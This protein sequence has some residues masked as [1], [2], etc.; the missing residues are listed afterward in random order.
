MKGIDTTLDSITATPEQGGGGGTSDYNQLSHKPTIDGKVIEGDGTSR[1]YGLVSFQPQET[2]F[3]ERQIARG[4]IDAH[5]LQVDGKKMLM[6]LHAKGF[7]SHEEPDKRS[8]AIRL[9]EESALG[10]Y[11]S[12]LGIEKKI[13]VPTLDYA[14]IDKVTI[15]LTEAVI[16]PSATSSKIPPF[17]AVF[18]LDSKRVSEGWMIVGCSLFEAKDG[19][20]N[21]VYPFVVQS[22]TMEGGSKVKVS[23]YSPY[24]E[25]G[26]EAEM[27]SVQATIARIPA[28]T[29]G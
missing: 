2:R 1:E 17:A 26:I 13:V 12:G 4:N 22:F 7:D 27:L 14:F 16:I 23:F 28:Q 15:K 24:P 20:G 18:E 6:Y 10:I 29:G 25:E 3:I 8:F 21:R 5:Y 19:K 9:V 11:F